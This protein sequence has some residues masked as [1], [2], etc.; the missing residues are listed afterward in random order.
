M[1]VILDK[2]KKIKFFFFGKL[3]KGITT[4]EGIPISCPVRVYSR[5]TGELLSKGI[6]KADGSYLLF[7]SNQSANYVLAIDPADE[8]NI[9]AQDNA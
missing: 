1:K 7:G 3:I 4:K 8:F 6:S 5:S 2:P 9:A